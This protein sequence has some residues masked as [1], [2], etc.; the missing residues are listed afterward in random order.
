MRVLITILILLFSTP[1]LAAPPGYLM[2]KAGILEGKLHIKDGK[3][4]VEGIIVSFFDTKSGPPPTYGDLRRVPEMVS[5][6]DAEGNFKVKLIP[7]SYNMGAMLRARGQGAGPPRSGEEY[8]FIVD[9]N[10]SLLTFEI[11]AKQTVNIGTVK[12]K[13]PENI[14]EVQNYFTV[15]GTVLDETGQPLEN[16]YILVKSDINA[17]RPL[18]ISEKTD[19]SG[20]YHMKL[21]AEKS[22]Y[23]LARQ[24]LR[25]GRPIA[26]SYVGTYG[27]SAPTGTEGE[28][29]IDAPVGVGGKGGQGEAIAITGNKGDIR[30]KVD[31]TMFKIPIPEENRQKF[32]KKFRSEK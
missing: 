29:G 27:K 16:A 24:N 22:Y 31:I 14:P 2:A 15:E 10:G 20:K 26:G 6:T 4:V 9:D 32:E 25:G 23:L 18:Y 3:P 8:F 1:C 12:G 7:G 19:K 13:K 30:K 21:P 5:R 28:Y 17:A 11:P